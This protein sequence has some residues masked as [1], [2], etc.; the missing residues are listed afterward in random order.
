MTAVNVSRKVVAITG[1][2]GGI[3]SEVA[4]LF[5]AGGDMVAILDSSMDK[6]KKA[7]SDIVAAGGSAHPYEVDV[8]DEL[9][10][11]QVVAAIGQDLGGIDVLVN[12]AA[13][14]HRCDIDKLSAA[15]WRHV[16]DINLTGTFL[17]CLASAPSMAPGSCIVNIGS[18]NA[19]R[20]NPN[21]I[22]YG[23]SKA[24]VAAL[25]QA[26]AVALAPSRIRVNGVIGGHVLTDFSRTRLA[27]PVM[28]S[29][30]EA[31]I[32]LAH[33]GDARNFATAI[34]FLASPESAWVTGAMLPVDGGF[35]AADTT[36]LL[37]VSV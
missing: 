37:P 22:A 5:A 32:P 18:I 14:I 30:V 31:S 1:G 2:G 34:R 23:V 35:L 24:G 10:V 9:S 25:T 6:A 36:A 29:R 16:I 17:M 7:A 4:C 13:V 8:S 28:R 26:L 21:I 12:G 3:C 15:D 20:H 11:R 19:V 33:L 27:D